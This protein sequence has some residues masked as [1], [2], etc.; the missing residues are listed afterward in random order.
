MTIT[1]VLRSAAI[2]TAVVGLVDPSWTARRQAPVAVELLSP[3]ATDG[4]AVRRRLSR[5]LGDAVTFASEA[6]PAALVVVDDISSTTALARGH[7]TGT[8]NRDTQPGQSRLSVPAVSTVYTARPAA[9]NVRVVAAEEPDPGRVGWSASFHGVIEANGLAGKSS[10]IVIEERGVELAHLEHR[11]T[12]DSERFEATLRYTPP[13][14]GTSTVTLRVLP[15]EGETTVSDNAADLRFVAS[16]RRLSVLVH[17]ARPSWNAAFV[18]RALEQDPSFDVSALVQ[19]SRGLEVR[20]G[21]PPGALT[22]DALSV[23]EAVVVGAPEELRPSEVEALQLFAR[24]RGGAVVLVPDRRPSGPYLDLIPAPQFDEVLLEN[25]IEL[26]APGGAVASMARLRA[27][28]MAAHRAGA[29]GAQVLATLEEKGSQGKAARAVVLEWPDGAGRVLFSGAMDAWRY[30]GTADDGFGRFWRARIAE[31]AAAAPA[32]VEV[33]VA[34][35]V[36][37]PGGAVTI[38]ARLR[39]TEFEQ[40]A[41]G[42]T[43]LPAVRAQLIG[44]DGAAQAIRLWPTA[45]LGTFEGR[46]EAPVVGTY[47]LQVSAATGATVDEVINVVAD[48]RQPPAA[49]EGTGTANRLVATATGGVAVSTSDLAPLERHLRSLASGEVERTVRPGRSWLLVLAFAVLLSAEWTMRRW[50]GRV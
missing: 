15:V 29:S 34:P 2:A 32:R 3:E 49:A 14:S 24:R 6:E 26:R 11:W 47:D 18:R 40:G 25:A 33:S 28:E 42:R 10:R 1:A 23:F 36:P 43:Q 27:S 17:E 9:P 35:G 22:A 31:G 4:D 20:A 7:S 39:P 46:L 44:S 5:S 8:L 45:E 21:T 19:A 50:R 37:R 38:R 48:A 13:A 41:P 30:R 12:S 16:G